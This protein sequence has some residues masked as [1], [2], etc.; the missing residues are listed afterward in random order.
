MYLLADTDGR[1]ALH[2]A[3]D[4]GHLDIVRLLISRGAQVNLKV[5]CQQEQNGLD[6]WPCSF[7]GVTVSQN[8]DVYFLFTFLFIFKVIVF[9]R[10]I[11]H[12]SL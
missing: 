7:I 11:A 6:C 9:F 1:T 2:W 8:S 10:V 12:F 5:W 3:A 4:Q